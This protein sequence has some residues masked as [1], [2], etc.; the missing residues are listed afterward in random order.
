V[1][2]LATEAASIVLMFVTKLIDVGAARRR[3]GGIVDRC[4]PE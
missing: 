4:S 2:P 3:G 1:R